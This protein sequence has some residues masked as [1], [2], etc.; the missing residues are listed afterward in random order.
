M[1]NLHVLL[2][3]IYSD[4][5]CRCDNLL[6]GAHDE[7]S[8][9]EL[10]SLSADRGR[11]PSRTSTVKRLTLV[12]SGSQGDIMPTSSEPSHFSETSGPEVSQRSDL[13]SEAGSIMSAPDMYHPEGSGRMEDFTAQVSAGRHIPICGA[14]VSCLTKG[15]L[16]E[17]V[18]YE[19]HP[20]RP[21]LQHACSDAW[22]RRVSDGDLAASPWWQ[23]AF[24]QLRWP[25]V[26][27]RSRPQRR[28][29]PTSTCCL[30][31]HPASWMS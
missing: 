22:L 4:L 30:L 12:P 2:W 26:T 3:A 5:A 16:P 29:W 15:R 7:I 23:Q 9:P 27:V 21:D 14:V 8:P 13:A 1:R 24:G 19:C 10:D 18:L 6:F 31:N 17:S 11:Y 25:E 20:Q 28:L